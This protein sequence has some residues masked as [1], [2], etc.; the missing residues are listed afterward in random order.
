MKMFFSSFYSSFTAA[1]HTHTHSTYFSC[2]TVFPFLFSK[3]QFLWLFLVKIFTVT[4]SLL[5]L[6]MLIEKSA[7]RKF[8][9]GSDVCWCGCLRRWGKGNP[10]QLAFMVWALVWVIAFG[11]RVTDRIHLAPKWSIT[12]LYWQNRHLSCG[13]CVESPQKPL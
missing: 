2:N 5:L 10:L 6:F 8:K 11:S 3:I 1:T 7:Q 9:R 13:H 4:T 12:S